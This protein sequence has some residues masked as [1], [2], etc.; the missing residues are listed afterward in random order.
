MEKASVRLI[1]K[2]DIPR[3]QFVDHE[4]L[5]AEEFADK[6]KQLLFQSMILGNTYH[7]KVKIVFET[8]EGFYEVE[9]TVWATTDDF[10]LLKGGVYLP[11]KC[12]HDVVIP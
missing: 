5:P 12:I 7:A 11:T 1:A 3:L 4:V 9:T 10:V 2:E 6:R 8:V